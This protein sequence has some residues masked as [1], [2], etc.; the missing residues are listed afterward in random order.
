[1]GPPP[2]PDGLMSDAQGGGANGL[3]QP[4]QQ[5]LP[6]PGAGDLLAPAVN[7]PAANG[8]SG[9]NGSGKQP[10]VPPQELL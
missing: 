1:M 9:S 4:G 10:A 3:Q 8:P 2:T 5:T 6:Q 7:P